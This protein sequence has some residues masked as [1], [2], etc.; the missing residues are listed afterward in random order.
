VRYAAAQLQRRTCLTWER[1]TGR[2]PLG[3]TVRPTEAGAGRT[4]S[5]M[6]K[7]ALGELRRIPAYAAD[8]KGFCTMP[9]DF[10]HELLES[11]EALEPAFSAAIKLEE[12][13]R[14]RA[15]KR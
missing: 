9:A 8:D 12:Q 11:V 6:C 10:P 13:R 15:A 3:W 1:Q 7:Y 4:P 14:A 5:V 2:L